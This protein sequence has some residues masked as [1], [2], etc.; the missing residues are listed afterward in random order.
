MQ[1]T[2]WIDRNFMFDTAI[3][4]TKNPKGFVENKIAAKQGGIPI[5]IGAGNARKALEIK[6]GER[7]VS[8][9]NYLPA[10]RQNKQLKK[11]K[12]K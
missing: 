10:A 5:I 3:V 6:S 11:S 8:E 9:K 1:R 12:K 4:K 2:K 7:V